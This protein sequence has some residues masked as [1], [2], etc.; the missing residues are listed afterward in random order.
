[1]RLFGSPTRNPLPVRHC[2]S[3]TLAVHT[4]FCGSHAPRL[5]PSVVNTTRR[6][7]WFQVAAQSATKGRAIPGRTACV[8]EGAPNTSIPRLRVEL[9]IDQGPICVTNPRLRP[10][11]PATR[12]VYS[13][14]ATASDAR[15]E[16]AK[17]TPARRSF[18]ITVSRS[19]ITTSNDLAMRGTE[20][21]AHVVL[22]CGELRSRRESTGPRDVA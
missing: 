22:G 9:F 19:S 14:C 18:L 17:A 10:D 7:I 6:P 8:D 21:R 16:A 15:R 5:K 4:A 20:I 13:A 12:I 1:M 11:P 2:L 3:V